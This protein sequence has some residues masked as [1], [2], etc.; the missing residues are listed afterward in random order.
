MV[1]PLSRR[2]GGGGIVAKGKTQERH[3]GMNKKADMS[4]VFV[5][6]PLTVIAAGI[7]PQTHQN[8]RR[9]HRP[10]TEGSVGKEPVRDRAVRRSDRVA[11]AGVQHGHG[12]GTRQ[13]IAEVAPQQCGRVVEHDA[14]YTAHRHGQHAHQ[15]LVGKAARTRTDNRRTYPTPTAYLRLCQCC[16]HDSLIVWP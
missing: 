4:S 10:I 7:H 5:S 15:R 6:L 9:R 2:A 1:I 16:G 13:C 3:I 12:L 14:G 11:S 8:D